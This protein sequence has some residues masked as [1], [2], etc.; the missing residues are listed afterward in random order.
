MTVDELIGPI[1]RLNGRPLDLDDS[2]ET[3]ATW[4]SMAHV[5]VVLALEEAIGTDLTA[6]EILRLRSVRGII[7]VAGARGLGLELRD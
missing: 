2:P 1:L 3:V 6:A 4:D 7:E 5:Q